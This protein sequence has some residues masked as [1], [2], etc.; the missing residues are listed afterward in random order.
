ME[1]EGKFLNYMAA[2]NML[3]CCCTLTTNL[4]V[5]AVCNNFGTE[6]G[7]GSGNISDL[8]LEGAWFKSWPEHHYHD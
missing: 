2:L 3:Y 4:T 7:S 8:Y 1:P 5:H 6:Q